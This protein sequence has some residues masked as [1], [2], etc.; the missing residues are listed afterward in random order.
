MG[1]RGRGVKNEG[2]LNFEGRPRRDRTGKVGEEVQNNSRHTSTRGPP[3]RAADRIASHRLYAN[4]TLL[5]D[6]FFVVWVE[7]SRC[8]GTLPSGSN[9]VLV[10]WC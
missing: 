9:S 3:L 10:T 8:P 4:C 2:R 6:A 7:F 1:D 5:F